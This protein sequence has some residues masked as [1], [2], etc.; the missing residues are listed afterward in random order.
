MIFITVGPDRPFDRLVKVVDNWVQRTARN[1]VVA[2]IGRGGWR[3]QSMR[4]VE[5]IEPPEFA[6]YFQ[7]ADVVISHAG[8]GTILSALHHGKPLIVM[9]KLASLGE[10]RNEHQTATARK[11]VAIHG[12]A[13]AFNEVELENQLDRISELEPPRR[14]GQSASDSLLRGVREFIFH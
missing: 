14:I 4:A 8:M 9:P 6:R 1:D 10:H 5:F 12:V 2:Q 11:M 7:Q 13:V 3:P